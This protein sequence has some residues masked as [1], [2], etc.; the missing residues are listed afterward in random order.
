M[1]AV[2]WLRGYLDKCEVTNIANCKENKIY[3]VL[4]LRICLINKTKQFCI[5][6]LFYV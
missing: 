1:D 4:F 3:F 5:Y 6:D 2:C